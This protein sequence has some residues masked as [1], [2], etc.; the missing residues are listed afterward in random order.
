MYTHNRNS[1]RARPLHI[2]T[3]CG[4]SL[5]LCVRCGDIGGSKHTRS[6]VQTHSREHKTNTKAYRGLT[7]H[8]GALVACKLGVR[9]Q[10]N[11]APQRQYH[12]QKN[13]EKRATQAIGRIHI[14]YSVQQRAILRLYRTAYIR[15]LLRQTPHQPFSCRSVIISIRF[16]CWN[17]IRM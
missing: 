17:S 15:G 4:N 11:A 6:S 16:F 3:P 8:Y 14:V 2:R 5:L 12:K 13:T 7:Q 10:R 1:S 9:R